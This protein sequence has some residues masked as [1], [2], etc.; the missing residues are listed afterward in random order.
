MTSKRKPKIVAKS[1]T[2]LKA[3][4]EPKIKREVFALPDWAH[5]QIVR[6]SGLVEDICQH[7]VGHPNRDYI[8]KYDPNGIRWLS[9]HGCCGEGCCHAH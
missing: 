6:E 4:A 5:H 7:G 9:I 2:K 1:K 3:K 8:R